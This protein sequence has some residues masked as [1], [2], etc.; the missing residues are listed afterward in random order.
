MLLMSLL[1]L[2]PHHHHQVINNFNPFDDLNLY[3][4]CYNV[5]LPSTGIVS[6]VDS[7]VGAIAGGYRI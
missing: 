1:L 4:G 3:S 2:Q 6:S 7:N 5:E